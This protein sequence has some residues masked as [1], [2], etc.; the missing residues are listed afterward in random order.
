VTH[1]IGLGLTNYIYERRPNT[2]SLKGLDEDVVGIL[3]PC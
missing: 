3:V 2:Q 1:F